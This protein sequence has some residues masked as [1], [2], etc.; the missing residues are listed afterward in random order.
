MWVADEASESCRRFVC[1]LLINLFFGAEIGTWVWSLGHHKLTVTL[2]TLNFW[3]LLYFMTHHNN[4]YSFLSKHEIII[5]TA[6][7]CKSFDLDLE[8]TVL[9]WR[10]L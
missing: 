4:E 5:P 3:F 9:R 6:V 8:H 1:G 10:F 2:W 7:W